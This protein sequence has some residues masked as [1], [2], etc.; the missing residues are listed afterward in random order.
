MSQ[1]TYISK[2][3]V[4]LLWLNL[5]PYKVLKWNPHLSK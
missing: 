4:I 5:K 1:I 3:V 2:V